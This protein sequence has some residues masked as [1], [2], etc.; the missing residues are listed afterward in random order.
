[1]GFTVARIVEDEILL[2]IGVYN[3]CYLVSLYCPK[4]FENYQKFQYFLTLNF[5][6]EIIL[7]N[8][9]YLKAGQR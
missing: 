3:F 2:E 1:M 9:R 7:E 6:L 4:F 5:A 8:G